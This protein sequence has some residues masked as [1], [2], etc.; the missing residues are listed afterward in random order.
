MTGPRIQRQRPPIR[1]AGRRERRESKGR[2][3]GAGGKIPLIGSLEISQGVE[4]FRNRAATAEEVQHPASVGEGPVGGRRHDAGGAAQAVVEDAHA[5]IERQHRSFRKVGGHEADPRGGAVERHRAPAKLERTEDV[6]RV[7]QPEVPI[8]G[9]DLGDAEHAGGVIRGQDAGKRG[10]GAVRTGHKG[11]R[12]RWG[13]I[14]DDRRDGGAGDGAHGK[15]VL[16]TEIQ[17]SVGTERDAGVRKIGRGTDN[18]AAGVDINGGEAG[19]DHVELQGAQPRLD[20]RRT[21]GDVRVDRQAGL[22]VGIPAGARQRGS[23]DLVDRH[24]GRAGQR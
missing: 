5:V 19:A 2:A 9:A 4:R 7:I 12:G 17:D 22:L 13:E 10:I 21:A 24:G 20:E 14:L 11:A 8:A 6:R 18:Q 23:R 1:A 15:S 16:S 3:S